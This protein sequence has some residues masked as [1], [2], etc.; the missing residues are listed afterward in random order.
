MDLLNE[1]KNRM[2]ISG[3][4]HNALILSYIE[5]VKHY[6]LSAGIDETVVNSRKAIGCIAKGVSDLFNQKDY[7]DFFKQRAI[8]LTF[9]EPTDEEEIP[10][11]PPA[12]PNEGDGEDGVQG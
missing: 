1:V 2:L 10:L 7:S 8:Q 5:D 3:D 11:L 4:Y 9:E 12:E 6:L